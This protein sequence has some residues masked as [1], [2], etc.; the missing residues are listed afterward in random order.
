MLPSQIVGVP[1]TAWHA[2]T[3]RHCSVS[4][5]IRDHLLA[6]QWYLITQPRAALLGLGCPR[7]RSICAARAP[8][9]G[10]PQVVL[11]CRGPS[12]RPCRFCGSITVE[13]SGVLAE[14]SP[15]SCRCPSA[16]VG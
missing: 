4:S 2:K 3:V 12:V 14:G 15:P 10:I 5:G 9:C 6:C 8:P 7:A 1:R 16:D 13:T 11:H